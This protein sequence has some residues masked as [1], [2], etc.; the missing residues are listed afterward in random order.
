MIPTME[1]PNRS[2]FF[3][4]ITDAVV[5]R[6]TATG[7]DAEPSKV[8]PRDDLFADVNEKVRRLKGRSVPAIVFTVN[9]REGSYWM[10]RQEFYRLTAE[11]DP[12]K[13][14]SKP[15]EQ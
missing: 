14:T 10:P 6:D 4:P 8:H 1:I 15:H 12:T 9:D 11:I 5:Y 3:G 7:D 13:R 2:K